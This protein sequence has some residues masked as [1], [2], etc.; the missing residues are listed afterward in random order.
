MLLIVFIL[1]G[2]VYL[3]EREVNSSLDSVADSL[4]LIWRQK[5]FTS[6]PLFQTAVV[7]TGSTNIDFI[8]PSNFGTYVVRAFATT[9]ELT[10]LHRGLITKTVL[11]FTSRFTSN[12]RL[13]AMRLMK[14]M[15][16]LGAAR[17]K[18]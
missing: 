9:G 6:T 3:A 13:T 15:E 1:N 5:S 7:T 11:P 10:H 18:L 17:K 4:G 2:V 16:C 8:A 12:C 14:G